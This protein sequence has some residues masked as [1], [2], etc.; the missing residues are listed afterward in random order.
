MALKSRQRLLRLG[1]R[2][3]LG[4]ILAIV[5]CPGSRAQAAT[6]Q[7]AQRLPGAP[8]APVTLKLYPETIEMGAFYNGTRLRMEG[9]V[10]GG[11]KVMVVIRGTSK[12][13]VFNK[14]ARV[15][16]IWINV[17]KV[18]VSGPPSLFLRFSSED[19]HTFL[20]HQTIDAYALDELSIRNRMRVRTERGVRDA[21]ALRQL[22]DDYVE[23]KKSDGSYRRLSDRVHVATGK[24][25]SEYYSLDIGWP[26]LALPGT[27]QVEVYACRD[28]RIIGQSGSA[29]RLVEVGF[30]ALMLI[31]AHEHP[32]G[33]GILAVL[34]AVIAGLGMDLLAMLISGKKK[35]LPRK[36]PQAQPAQRARGVAAS[37]AGGPP[38]LE[39]DGGLPIVEIQP[40]HRANG[41]AAS[42]DAAEGSDLG[43]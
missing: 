26:K 19:V 3:A 22:A 2:L 30:P 32:I 12:D 28:G 31:T 4:A 6:S 18:H 34:L 41:P 11:S 5:Y 23:L 36:A 35:R 15:G 8:D 37:S 27:Y 17:D 42:G 1:V 13:E 16:P 7:Q 40:R 21:A 10:P 33:Y 14:K 24:D 25:G 43:P 20:D 38:R 9:S 29:L 39:Q